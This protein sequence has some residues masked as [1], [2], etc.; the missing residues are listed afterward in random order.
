MNVT[1]LRNSVGRIGT[2]IQLPFFRRN[3]PFDD[4]CARLADEQQPI[5]PA[6][7][8][9][10][11]AFELTRSEDVRV[12]IVGQEPYPHWN[13]RL[14]KGLATGLA[15]AVPDCTVALPKSLVNIFRNTPN[16]PNFRTGQNLEYW[17]AQGVLLLNLTLTIPVYNNKGLRAG[18][19]DGHRYLRWRRLI[20]DVVGR[21][22][23]KQNV[24]FM[25]FGSRARDIRGIPPRRMSSTVHP[26]KDA[27]VIPNSSLNP[28]VQADLFFQ[29]LR[30]PP[31]NW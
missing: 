25:L 16:F 7:G 30:E 15:F 4:I 5:I 31:I 3:G 13:S 18:E 9:I 20:N 2:W 8:N 19:K 17:A 1:P 21:L 12:V 6:G 14:E 28:F 10:L 23:N 22:A 24:F 26:S 29:R 27:F 11:R